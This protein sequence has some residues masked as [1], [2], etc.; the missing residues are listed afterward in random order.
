MDEAKW[1]RWAAATGFAFFALLVLGFAIVPAAPPKANDSVAKITSYYV[2]HRKALLIAGYLGGLSLVFGLWF[3]GSLRSYLRQAEG[4][5]GRLS[6]VAFGAALVSAA[7]AIFSGVA[8]N[9]LAFK[10]AGTQGTAAVVRTLFDLS[11]M[12]VGFLWFPAAVWAA[13]T[14]T[15]AWRTGAFPKWYAQVSLLGAI[16]FVVGGTSVYVDNGALATGGVYGF[17]VFIVFALWILVTTILLVQR[18]GRP[19]STSSPSMVGEAST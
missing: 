5:V 19:L 4:G 1:E 14:G 8:T 7:V 9:A 3:I 10:I 13:A 12:A 18:V 11:S 6:A 15:V 16:V 17:I 2:D